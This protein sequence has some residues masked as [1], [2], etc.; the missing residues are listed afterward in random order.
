MLFFFKI[1][2]NE[3]YHSDAEK[4]VSI[5]LLYL[6]CDPSAGAKYYSLSLSTFVSKTKSVSVGH[7]DLGVPYGPPDSRFKSISI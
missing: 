3:S 1:S 4:A 2:Q 6:V 7:A 5:V